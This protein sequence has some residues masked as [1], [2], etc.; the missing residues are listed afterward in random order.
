MLGEG[1]HNFHHT[2]PQDYR[3]HESNHLNFF[4]G[5][6]QMAQKLGFVYDLKTTSPE[7]I[8]ARMKRTGDG[9]FA[10]KED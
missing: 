4:T 9:S 8:A 1:P 10:F 3:G 7:I 2:F 5:V 6:I